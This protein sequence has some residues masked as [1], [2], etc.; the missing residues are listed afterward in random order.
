MDIIKV[1]QRGR[2]RSLRTLHIKIYR[3]PIF[4]DEHNPASFGHE[5]ALPVVFFVFA[6]RL[7]A[8][9]VMAWRKKR[10]GQRVSQDERTTLRRATR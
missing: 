7:L 8:F 1:V 3:H 2:E 5:M 4:L 10:S 9:Y 6:C